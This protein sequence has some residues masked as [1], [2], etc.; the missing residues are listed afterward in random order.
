MIELAKTIRKKDWQGD[1]F[2]VR[3]TLEPKKAFINVLKNLQL[4]AEAEKAKLEIDRM[5]GPGIEQMVFSLYDIERAVVSRGI[6]IP[7]AK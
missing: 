5:D 2:A 7:D 3:R 1:T 6:Q 4:L